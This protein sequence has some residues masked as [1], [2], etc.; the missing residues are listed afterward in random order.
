[1]TGVMLGVS[2]GVQHF[3]KEQAS[4][5]VSIDSVTSISKT[6]AKAL[7]LHPDLTHGYHSRVLPMIAAGDGDFTEYRLLAQLSTLLWLSCCHLFYYLR[8]IYEL[9]F[10]HDILKPKSP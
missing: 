6:K 7:L 2:Q 4:A 10:I 5:V 9:G 3:R 1:M 8:Q